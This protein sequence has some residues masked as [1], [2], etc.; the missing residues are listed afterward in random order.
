MLRPEWIGAVPIDTARVARASFPK[1]HLYLRVADEMGPLFT[2]EQFADL[3]P[4]HGQ[5]ALAP[6]R[7]AVV[8]ILR[9]AE[10][11]SDR[12]A[13]DAVR[14]RIDW[15]YVLRLELTDS[16]FDASVLSEFRSRLVAGQAE[17]RL[18]D[19]LL[20][21]CRERKLLKARGKQRSDSTHV[22]A[23][24]RALNRVE[25]V[26]EAMRAVLNDLAVVAP[27]WLSTIS[28]P[29]WLD[30]YAHRAEHE[31][32]PTTEA[33]RAALVQTV[34]EDGGT[35][36]G[37]IFAPEA[38]TWFRAIPTVNHLRQIWVQQY[39]VD[40]GRLR[41]RTEAD[42]LPSSS[43]FFSSPYDP[44][45]RLA[46][47]G[48]TQWVGYKIH[49]TE[50][51]EEDLPELITNVE[52]TPAPMADG[53]VTPQIHSHLKAN[54]LLPGDHIVDT[55]FLDVQLLVASQKD[56]GVNL[57]GPTRA[58]YHWQARAGE[59]FA[60]KDFIIDWAKQGVIC[61]AGRTSHSWTPAVD[62]R[63]TAVIK[64]K[65]SFRDCSPCIFRTRCFQATRQSG[66]RCLTL[67]PKEQFEALQMAREREKTAEFAALYDQ[68][69]G[70]EGTL[71]RGV[72]TCGM[73]RTRYIGMS[74]T[75]LGHVF[76]AV[77]INFLRLA[78][79]FAEIPRPKTRLSPFVCLM[80]Q[81]STA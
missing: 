62:R 35:L 23:A 24:V 81:S 78:E 17:T 68:R 10:D 67:R 75:H 21:W 30:R 42:G 50:T 51:C 72:R 32:L 37:A 1:G 18:L 54:D 55:G 22:L 36:L 20:A 47:K 33:E 41:W 77:A 70:V 31:H 45:V 76:T 58:D 59:G 2:D 29:P 14:S 65:F 43:H 7:L 73:R 66:R 5:P 52:T 69:A 26:V 27:D 44:D 38:P 28:P 39:V 34:G 60:A 16:G 71:S 61:P 49:L 48:T 19:T 57:V 3:Y 25:L 40:A 13:A 11:L 74:K 6:W 64:I 56:F 9:F 63:H 79:W 12:Q 46:K 80:N 8:T 15:K 53:E 4:T